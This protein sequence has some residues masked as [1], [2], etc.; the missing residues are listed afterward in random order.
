[1]KNKKKEKNSHI[2]AGL[3]G[4]V[5]NPTSDMVCRQ[6]TQNRGGFNFFS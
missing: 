5:A 6:I 1:M 2:I 4:L 3:A